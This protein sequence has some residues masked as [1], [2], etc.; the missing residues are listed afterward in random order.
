MPHF[1]IINLCLYEKPFIIMLPPLDFLKN[2]ENNVFLRE[3]FKVVKLR[4][5]AQHQQVLN[6]HK[7]GSEARFHQGLP[8][9]DA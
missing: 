1:F 4:R 5:A 9:M 8:W 3:L 7:T 2:N 6:S